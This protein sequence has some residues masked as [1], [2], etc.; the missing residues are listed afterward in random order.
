MSG[1]HTVQ[2]L[3]GQPDTFHTDRETDIRQRNREAICSIERRQRKKSN[4]KV[5]RLYLGSAMLSK[6]DLP[7]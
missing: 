6:F 1:I 3:R 7:A 4:P 2:I 5:P